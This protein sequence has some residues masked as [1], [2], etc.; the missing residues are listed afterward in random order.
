MVLGF[1][2]SMLKNVNG[3]S[4]SSIKNGVEAGIQELRTSV[5]PIFKDVHNHQVIPHGKS[6]TGC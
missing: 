3:R 1:A 4:S 2:E 5:S 6:M